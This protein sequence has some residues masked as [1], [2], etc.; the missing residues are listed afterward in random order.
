MLVYI[1]AISILIL[2][3]IMLTQTKFGPAELV[4]HRQWWAGALAAIGV[5]MLLLIARRQHDLAAGRQPSDCRR[6]RPRSRCCCSTT[7]CTSSPCRSIA[8]LLT[9]AVVG[10]VFLAKREVTCP[11]PAERDVGHP[12][13]G[14]RAGR[15][16]AGWIQ[17]V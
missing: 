1:G 8:I 9:A 5:G 16:D 10:A 15:S 13:P 11:I 7:R 6:R 4:F 2:F 3:A 12:R 17:P 14:A